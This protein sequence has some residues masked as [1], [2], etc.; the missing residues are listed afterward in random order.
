MYLHHIPRYLAVAAF[1]FAVSTIA[2]A[3]AGP[4]SRPEINA[5][6]MTALHR[7]PHGAGT[8]GECN[9]T[10]YGGGS[11]SGQADLVKRVADGS[12][13][14]NQLWIGQIYSNVVGRHPNSAEC[15]PAKYGSFSSYMDLTA[16]IQNY[17]RVAQQLATLQPH[18]LLVLSN[19]DAVDKS[20]AIVAKAGTYLV[21]SGGGNLVAS[22]GGNLVAS[23][24]GNLVA[25]GG[26]NIISQD[27]AGFHVADVGGKR[28]L[29]RLVR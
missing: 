13:C 19:G 29:G 26:G 22:G 25:A 23:G 24:G 12:Y 27:G 8:S 2:H 17:Q 11:W 9:P 20:G 3:Q 15:D 5:A 10:A 18:Q 21:A 1:A 16:K 14:S 7:A 6:Y 28:V 4:C